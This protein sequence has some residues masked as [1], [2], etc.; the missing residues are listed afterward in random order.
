M[1]DYPPFMNA[2]GS[3]SKILN[4]ILEAKTPQRFTQDYL[5]KTLGFSGGN[6][7][8]FIPLAKRMGLLS[9][10]GTPTDIYNKFRDLNHSKTAMAQAVRTGYSDLFTRNETAHKLDRKGLEGL[11]I[12]CTGLDQGS[13]TLRAIVGTFEALKAFANFETTPANITERKKREEDNQNMHSHSSESSDGGARL[14]L[15]YNINLNLPKSDDPAV[16]N[17]IFRALREHILRS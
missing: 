13:K 7:R 5:A 4:K 3:V 9:S 10:D 15:S 8:P 6:Y 12:Q 14:S 11:V 1:A 17:A 2:Y 16:F